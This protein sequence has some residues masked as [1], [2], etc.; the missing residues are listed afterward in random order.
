MGT[1]AR[2]AMTDALADWQS[3]KLV[4]AGMLASRNQKPILESVHILGEPY[5]RLCILQECSES[6]NQS[7]KQFSPFFQLPICKDQGRKIETKFEAQFPNLHPELP[8][9]LV[10]RHGAT[11]VLVTLAIRRVKTFRSQ[12]IHLSEEF[13]R[14][15]DSIFL[16]VGRKAPVAKHLKECV[17]VHIFSDIIKIVMLSSS[18]DALLRVCCTLQ[19]SERAFRIDCSHEDRFELVHARIREEESWII[20]RQN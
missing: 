18:T 9:F 2:A 5:S 7:I 14:P 1:S 4:F 15:S 11:E 6:K 12:S 3:S 20:V 17:V 10:R 16:E 13:P 8:C 19:I